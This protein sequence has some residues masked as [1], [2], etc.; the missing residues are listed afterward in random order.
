[1]GSKHRAAAL[2]SLLP[3][4]RELAFDG[5][6]PPKRGIRLELVLY[7][8]AASEKCQLAL[9]TLQRVLDK[10]DTSQVSVTVTD[11]SRR[12]AGG[13]EDAVIFTPTLVKRGPGP[14]TW[15]VE[16][17]DRDDLLIELFEVSGVDRKR[18]AR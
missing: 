9:R 5:H 1:M 18:E 4:R 11:L 17:L 13:D 3:P 8:S 7:T 16:N 10:Y 2:F 6:R 12:P 15:I 14:R